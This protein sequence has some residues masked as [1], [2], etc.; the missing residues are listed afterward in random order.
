MSI[1][2]FLFQG[3][4]PRTWLL[5]GCQAARAPSGSQGHGCYE[6]MAMDIILQLTTG[7]VSFDLP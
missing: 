2:S 6:V 5:Y 3:P 7:Q 1:M 4:I